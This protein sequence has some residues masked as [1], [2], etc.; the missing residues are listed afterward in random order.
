M[1]LFWWLLEQVCQ[2]LGSE[3]ST[4]LGL[5]RNRLL[6]FGPDRPLRMYSRDMY[7]KQTCGSLEN[8][9]TNIKSLR[10]AGPPSGGNSTSNISEDSCILLRPEDLMFVVQKH[11]DEWRRL[12]SYDAAW[13]H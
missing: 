12:A 1:T 8:V 3:G 13:S 5:Q 10:A 6:V 11:E 2:V 7:R 9:F 4:V